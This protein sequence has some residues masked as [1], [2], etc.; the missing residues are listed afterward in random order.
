MSARRSCSRA[1]SLSGLYRGFLCL[2][3]LLRDVLTPLRA[4]VG[5]A[6]TP[7]PE[8]VARRAPSRS[9][10]VRHRRAR[11]LYAPVLFDRPAA[12][13]AKAGGSYR[14]TSARSCTFASLQ[15]RARNAVDRRW[16]APCEEDSILTIKLSHN[17][18][19]ADF[20]NFTSFAFK[21]IDT[22]RLYVIG[23]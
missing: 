12:S 14:C 19:F 9:P 10:R 4:A 23:K 20:P 8:L 2:N 11:Q 3:A 16:S 18:Q 7:R 1:L 6:V 13:A 21:I 5:H 17:I 15:R 22:C